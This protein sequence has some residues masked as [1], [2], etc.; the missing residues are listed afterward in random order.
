MNKKCIILAA[1]VIILGLVFT[2]CSSKPE[3]SAAGNSVENPGA[4]AED[5]A[6]GG[7]AGGSEG[8]GDTGETAGTGDIQ[9]GDGRYVRT[10]RGEGGVQVTAVWLS[11][12]YLRDTGTG[13]YDPEKNLLFEISMGTHMGDLREYP[14]MQNAELTVNGAIIKP[15]KWEVTNDDSHHLSGRLIFEANGETGSPGVNSGELYLNLKDLRGVPERGFTW[16][17]I[18]TPHA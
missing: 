4:A 11:P 1:M 12:E 7:D 13:D 3:S 18:D 6:A 5:K 2:G 15:A 10:D 9:S 14:I 8:T 16:E 17:N